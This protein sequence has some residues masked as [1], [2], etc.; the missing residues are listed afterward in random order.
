MVLATLPKH[1]FSHF[2]SQPFLIFF[3]TSSL[4]LKKIFP[5]QMFSFFLWNLELKFKSEENKRPLPYFVWNEKIHFF[6]FPCG[7]GYGIVSPETWWHF[8]V[9]GV[10]FCVKP[11]DCFLYP[12]FRTIVKNQGW[13][14]I[15]TNV[16]P[17]LDDILGFIIPIP[18]FHCS[19]SHWLQKKIKSFATSPLIWLDYP[20]FPHLLGLGLLYL[21]GPK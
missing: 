13:P 12:I 18:T 16:I 21:L 14:T 2:L 4:F 17:P 20:M 3:I 8:N 19:F 15:V 1:F 6:S 9:K 5:P 11:H 7:G 10:P